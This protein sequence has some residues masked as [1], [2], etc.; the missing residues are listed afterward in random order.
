MTYFGSAVVQHS[1]H[2]IINNLNYRYYK[3]CLMNTIVTTHIDI[4]SLCHSVRF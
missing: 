3:I 2:D 1:V 4:A